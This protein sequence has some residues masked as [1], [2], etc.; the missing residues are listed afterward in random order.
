M[1]KKRRK[2]IMD[3]TVLLERAREI[4]D[5]AQEEEQECYDNLPEGIQDSERGEAM[6]NNIEA[7]QTASDGIGDAV[8][9]LSEI[10]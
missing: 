6:Y 10:E 7:L 2:N 8:D 4:I 1:N 5:N 3:A 9:S